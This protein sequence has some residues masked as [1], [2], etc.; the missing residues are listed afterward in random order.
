MLNITIRNEQPA[1]VDTITCVTKSAFESEQFASHTEQFI[2]NSLRHAKQLVVSLVAL[3]EGTIVGH[4]ALSPVSI[5]SGELGWY[6][7]G[8]VSVLPQWQGQGV[9]TQLIR[10]G[11]AQ[12]QR[13]GARG[14][15]VLGSPDFYGRFGFKANSSLVYADA[16]AQ[17]FQAISFIGDLPLGQVSFHKAFEVTE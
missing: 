7:L 15:V 17:Y 3:Y 13:M 10:S 11:L 16:P 9:G 8:P 6:G 5:S 14:C 12:L 1:D 4:I 2:V